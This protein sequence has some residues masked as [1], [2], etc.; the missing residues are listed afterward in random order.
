MTCF[1][2]GTYERGKRIAPV[3]FSTTT[4]GGATSW[5]VPANITEIVAKCWGAGGG[6]GNGF[7]FPGVT[8]LREVTRRRG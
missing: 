6:A 4:E 5:V 8:V 7:S 3:V 1:A 2:F